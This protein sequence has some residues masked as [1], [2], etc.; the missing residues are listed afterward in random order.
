MEKKSAMTAPLLD[1]F[2]FVINPPVIVY[3]VVKLSTFWQGSWNGSNQI[4]YV[5]SHMRSHV[6]A[7]LGASSSFWPKKTQIL[8]SLDVFDVW[9]FILRHKS[10]HLERQNDY[11]I[12]LQVIFCFCDFFPIWLGLGVDLHCTK[13]WLFYYLSWWFGG[14]FH[15]YMSVGWHPYNVSTCKQFLSVAETN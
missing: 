2:N 14:C 11:F 1:S 4:S 12:L 13:L 7:T 5:G 8:R 9:K 15:T 10:W 3:T 6:N